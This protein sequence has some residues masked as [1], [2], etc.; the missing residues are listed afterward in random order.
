MMR[1]VFKGKTMELIIK[2][3]ED[4]DLNE[5]FSAVDRYLEADIDAFGPPIAQGNLNL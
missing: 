4:L 5:D 1:P 3:F 2:N